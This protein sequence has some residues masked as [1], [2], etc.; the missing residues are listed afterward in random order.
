MTVTLV[1]ERHMESVKHQKKYKAK[2]GSLPSKVVTTIELPE[3]YLAQGI[4]VGDGAN[5]IRVG[6]FKCHI[7]DA[8]PFNA[9]P[10]IKAHLASKRHQ[11]ATAP[12][13]DEDDD[14]N[15]DPFADKL[16]NMPD[17]VDLQAEHLVC[18]L[19]PSKANAVHPMYM[20]IHGEK[21]AR[22]CRTLN[23]PEVLWIKE[24]DRLEEMHSGKP[25]VRT[26]F[27]EP[28][29]GEKPAHQLQ[30]PVRPVPMPAKPT[31]PPGGAEAAGGADEVTAGETPTGATTNRIVG[32]D[33]AAEVTQQ[34]SLPKGWKHFIDT[35]S[36]KPFFYHAKTRMT[37]WE[38]PLP[39]RPDESSLPPGWQI[40]WSD[41][42]L[43][44]YFA[45]FETQTSCFEKP[46]PYEPQD[47][48]RQ[49]DRALRKAFW[50]SE[51]LQTSFCEE[52]ARWAR[53][54]DLQ[55][56]IYWSNAD[57]GLRFYEPTHWH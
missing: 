42:H 46:T 16:W 1:V 9:L 3:E 39:E 15:A 44:W 7:C 17:Y 52:D 27:R 14:A 24:R 13:E 45:D 21:H 26:G 36:G 2:V 49:I 28:R 23:L 48:K 56:R 40:V 18:T 34:F 10:T 12:E 22:K 57:E 51:K 20:H 29:P 11:K 50:V 5:G 25:V 6:E 37:Q 55:R 4:I 30:P 33:E 47:W 41:E 31:R 35:K 38:I 54:Q 19:C 8:G 53:L 32:T 43:N